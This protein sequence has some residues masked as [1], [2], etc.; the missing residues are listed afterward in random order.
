[1]VIARLDQA[2]PCRLNVHASLLG[3]QHF[4]K[5][6]AIQCVGSVPAGVLR[7]VGDILSET[8]RK[9][10]V[11]VSA[12]QSVENFDAKSATTLAF[13]AAAF[14]AGSASFVAC[15][16][17]GTIAYADASSDSSA[18]LVLGQILNDLT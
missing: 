3:S 8:G 18:S 10:D 4:Q 5:C 16:V 11:Q 17:S 9:F 2:T 13:A 6:G 7:D 1:M 14:T 12:K 15:A